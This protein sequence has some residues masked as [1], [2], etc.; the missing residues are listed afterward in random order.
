MSPN[1]I[2]LSEYSRSGWCWSTRSLMRSNQWR[3]QASLMPVSSHFTS[4]WT[5]GQVW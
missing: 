5:S 1:G 2:Q 4:R 3:F